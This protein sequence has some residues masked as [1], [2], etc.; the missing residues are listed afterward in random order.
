MSSRI[1]LVLD[2]LL[3]EA[4]VLGVIATRGG[5]IGDPGVGVGGNGILH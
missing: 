4:D 3:K 1:V 2:T 5:F